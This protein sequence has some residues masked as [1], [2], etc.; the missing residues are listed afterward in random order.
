MF[1]SGAQRSQVAALSRSECH[2]TRP[3]GLSARGT[4]VGVEG[5]GWYVGCVRVEGGEGCFRVEAVLRSFRE[6]RL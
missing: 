4:A 6:E 1:F 2:I 5:V 3:S